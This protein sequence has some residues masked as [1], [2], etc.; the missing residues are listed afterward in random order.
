MINDRLKIDNNQANLFARRDIE[1]KKPE[2]LKK[3]D[4]LKAI[5]TNTKSTKNALKW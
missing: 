4:D 2:L 3:L 1:S 5:E